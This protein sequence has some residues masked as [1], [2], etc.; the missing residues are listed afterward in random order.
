MAYATV[1]DLTDS[2]VLGYAA[3]A[4]A[5][6]LLDRASRDIDRALSTATYDVDTSGNPTD[7]AV[8]AALKDATLEQAA[9]QLESGNKTGIRHDLQSGVPSGTSA[10]LVELSRGP[11]VGGATADLPWLADQAAWILRSTQG[12]VWGPIPV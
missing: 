5:Q 9:Y 2:N 10:G 7:V 4:N 6:V 3:P 1:Q 12:I 8:I 11:S